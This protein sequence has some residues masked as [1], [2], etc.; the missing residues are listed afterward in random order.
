MKKLYVG[1]LECAVTDEDLQQLFEAYDALTGE[2]DQALTALE[3]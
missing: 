3:S 1:N 2:V